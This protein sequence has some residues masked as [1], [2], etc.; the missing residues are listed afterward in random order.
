MIAPRPNATVWASHES[1]R[2]KNAE[3]LSDSIP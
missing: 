3:E 2:K 1:V